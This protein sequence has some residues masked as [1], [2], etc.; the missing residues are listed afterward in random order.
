M[1]ANGLKVRFIFQEELFGFTETLVLPNETDFGIA[2]NKA[3][4]YLKNRLAMSG[5][6]VNIIGV[7]ISQ[8]QGRRVFRT[9]T[10]ADFPGL[11]IAKASLI[12]SSGSQPNDA[13]PA[14]STLMLTM[15][16]GTTRR[17]KLYLAGMPDVVMRTDPTGPDLGVSVWLT[18]FNTWAA[19][20]IADGWGFVGI[21]LEAGAF[22]PQQILSVG[23]EGVTNLL[24]AEVGATGSLAA[25][26]TVLVRGN[27]RINPAFKS[28][29]GRW[30]IKSINA[31]GG[32]TFVTLYGTAGIDSTKFRRLG[33]LTALDYTAFPV[34]R[35]SQ[36]RQTARKRGNRFLVPRARSR[37]VQKL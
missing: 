25:G 34:T 19:K 3:G 17:K 5:F 20:I 22:A 23:V 36:G 27:T 16:S 9:L 21:T 29:N 7:V 37:V 14:K 28:W 13:D 31:A 30:V 33:T 32:S 4:T 10:A 1:P 6:G 2:Q 18:A 35:V 15:E 8:L 24:I 26:G 11:S 12:G